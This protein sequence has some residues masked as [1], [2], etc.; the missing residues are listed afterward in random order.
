[1]LPFVAKEKCFPV[2]S[3]LKIFPIEWW[4]MVYR[5]HCT[6]TWSQVRDK[7]VVKTIDI[8]NI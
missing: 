1:M 3:S 8:S 6:G 5:N 4:V 2:T 7:I